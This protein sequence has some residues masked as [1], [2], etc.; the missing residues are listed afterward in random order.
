MVFYSGKN[1]RSLC[2]NRNDSVYGI[3]ESVDYDVLLMFTRFLTVLQMLK[4]GGH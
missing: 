3:A 2:I 1:E 4:P